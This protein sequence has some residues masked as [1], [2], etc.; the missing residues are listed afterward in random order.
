M[1]RLRDVGRVRAQPVKR[2]ATTTGSGG[3]GGG[4]GGGPIV[5][6]RPIRS[7][8]VLANHTSVPGPEEIP[9]GSAT[10]P[11][12]SV[13]VVMSPAVVMRPIRKLFMLVNQRLPSGP[14]VI[15]RGA[16]T[17]F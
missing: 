7:L 10:F 15:P 8:F 6:T 12:G 9:R 2:G 14:A 16:S 1:W 17:P 11:V 13:N 5:A 3:V 4:P